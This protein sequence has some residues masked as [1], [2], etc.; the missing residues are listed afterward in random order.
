[1]TSYTHNGAAHTLAQAARA[2]ANDACLGI[3]AGLDPMTDTDTKLRGRTA[4]LLALTEARHRADDAIIE[5]VCGMR[6]DG[7]SWSEV[8]RCLGITRQAAQQRYG[9][10]AD[11]YARRLMRSDMRATSSTEAGA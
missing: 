1:M 10:A 8:S 7:A 6:F 2:S 4:A 3:A 11:L 9:F 5:L